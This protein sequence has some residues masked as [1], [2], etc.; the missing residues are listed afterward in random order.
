MLSPGE[1]PAPGFAIEMTSVIEPLTVHGNVWGGS[2]V[3]FGGVIKTP[4][5]IPPAEDAC[6]NAFAEGRTK[7]DR[8]VASDFAV[9]KVA[10]GVPVVGGGEAFAQLTAMLVTD[11]V[12]TVPAPFTTAQFCPEGCA[13]TLTL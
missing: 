9:E 11:P 7:L 3:P 5:G 8:L 10:V 13:L 6:T 4:S 1:I 2:V 12:A